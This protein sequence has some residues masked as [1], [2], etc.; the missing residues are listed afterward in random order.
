MLRRFFI[1]IASFIKT[2]I[3]LIT[4]LIMIALID[5]HF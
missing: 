2:H 5:L 4:Y 1:S 3:Y